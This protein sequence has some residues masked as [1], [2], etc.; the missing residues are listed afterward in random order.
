[1]NRRT[2]VWNGAVAGA[3]APHV[4]GAQPSA[5]VYRLG[6]IGLGSPP[7]GYS[8]RPADP[9]WDAFHD[10]ISRA[11]ALLLGGRASMMTS[12][13]RIGSAHSTS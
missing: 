5:R 1:M 9:Q 7:G 8:G 6:Y 13:A 2:F 11:M 4:L 3:L 12:A 10:E